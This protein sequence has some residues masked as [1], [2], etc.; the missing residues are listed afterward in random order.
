M[1]AH[2]KETSQEA[3]TD[4]HRQ[5][6]REKNMIYRS[7]RKEI[8]DILQNAESGHDVLHGLIIQEKQLQPFTASNHC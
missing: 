3:D 2:G 8:N 5:T 7:N 6:D 4:T 1:L